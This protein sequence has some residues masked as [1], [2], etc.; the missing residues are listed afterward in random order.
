MLDLDEQVNLVGC[1][2]DELRSILGK[3]LYKDIEL[4]TSTPSN[5]NMSYAAYLD[6]V[7]PH[8]LLALPPIDIRGLRSRIVEALQEA[9][10]T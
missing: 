2:G 1:R 7:T 3:S 4:Q 5:Y 9:Q 6:F 8:I 10:W